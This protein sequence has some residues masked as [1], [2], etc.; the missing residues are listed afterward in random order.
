MNRGRNRHFIYSKPV[1]QYTVEGE[2]VT[3]FDTMYD[4]EKL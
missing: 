1:S 2:L 4:A 3:N